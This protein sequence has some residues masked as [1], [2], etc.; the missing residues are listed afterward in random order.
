MKRTITSHLRRIA[1]P[2]GIPRQGQRQFATASRAQSTI[3]RNIGLAVG[4]IS[5]AA[6][7][8][9][10]GQTSIAHAHTD[11]SGPL[12][13][14]TKEGQQKTYASP[15]VV[16]KVIG[17]LRENLKADQV[18]LREDQVSTD[19]DDR[20]QHGSSP[21]TYHGEHDFDHTTSQNTLILS[22][23]SWL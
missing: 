6:I 5:V 14:A 19:K 7:S 21:N 1:T 11:Q 23:A 16:Q 2:R 17:L 22:L 12:K 8:Y 10:F 4:A 18:K 3:S 20:L 13:T 15:E 9:S